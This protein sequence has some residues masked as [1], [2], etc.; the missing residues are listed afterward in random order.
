MGLLAPLAAV[1]GPPAAAQ[2]RIDGLQSALSDVVWIAVTGG[3]AVAA[4]AAFW[5]FLRDRRDGKL[6]AA[7][8][9]ILGLR[10]ALDRT[11][12]LLDADDQRTVIWDSAVAAPQVFGGLPERVGAPADKAAFLGF[13]GWLSPESATEI[14]AAADKL[15]REGAGFQIAARSRTGALVEVTGR[16][17]GRRALVRLRELTGERRSFA[18]LKEQAIHIV[19]ELT[20]LRNLADIVPLP[21]WRRNRNGR[22]TWVNAAYV[23]AVEAASQEAV[24]SSGIELLPSRTREA[25][26]ETQRAGGAYRDTATAV[27]AGDRRRLQ[28]IDM[29]IAEGSAGCA[30]DLSELESLRGELARLAQST[31]RTLDQLTAGVAVFDSNGGLL[32]HNAAFRTIWDISPDFL[33]SGPDES[34]LLDQL[35]AERKLPE[36]ANYRDWRS[37]HLAGY[38]SAQPREEL[39]HLP[40][41]RTLRMVAM[42]NGDGGLTYIY[43]N[44]T[45]RMS[46][47]SRLEALLQ[48]QGETLDH[49]S[50]AVAVFGTDGRLRLFN[51]ALVNMWKLSPARLRA[52]PHIGDIIADCQAIFAEK[53]PWEDIRTAVTNIDHVDQARGRMQRPDGSVLDYATVALPEGMTMLTFVDVTD[54]ANIQRMLRE[55]NEALEA[56]DR[57]KSDFIQHV[58][59][60]LRSPLQTIIGFSELLSDQRTGTL[61]PQQREYMDHIDASSRA[62]LSLINDILDLATVDAGIMTLDIQETDVGTLVTSSVE[63]LRD[64][65]AEQRLTLDVAVPKDIGVFHVDEQR[66]RQILFNLVSNAIRFSNAG[67]TIRI[68]AARSGRMIVFKVIDHGIGIP[69]DVLPSVFEPFETHAAQG[70][71]GGAGLGLSIVKRLVELHGGSVEIRS[72]EGKGTTAIVRLPSFP[73]AT[74]VAAE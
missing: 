21:L 41:R 30:I 17:S 20:A 63:A 2:T 25:I 61:A 24:L 66:M 26:R 58:S 28:V 18:E 38:R 8:A 29:P 35:R 65:L 1:I 70:R 31:T 73:V 14:E 37:R 19:N 39:W 74:A 23:K 71:R 52:E 49:L 68:E 4:I 48:L 32:F 50:E 46:L 54:S 62:L 47:E 40:D 56:A 60:E 3:T 27:V 33:A 15:R 43:E 53:S 5:L 57:L 72:E 69:G 11:E 42:P 64:R 12:G 36:Q 10:A 67:D 44:V 59:Y 55:R 51:P 34:A 22:L 45:E 9:E 6:A 7:Q 13:H 16:T